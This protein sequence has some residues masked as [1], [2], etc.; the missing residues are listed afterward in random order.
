MA[1]LIECRT[2]MSCSSTPGAVGL[3]SMNTTAGMLPEDLL[4][5]FSGARLFAPPAPHASLFSASESCLS[6]PAD[7]AEQRHHDDE[8]KALICEEKQGGSRE[9]DL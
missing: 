3:V 2:R 4:E 8:R 9:R 1:R 7:C 5:D 6:G